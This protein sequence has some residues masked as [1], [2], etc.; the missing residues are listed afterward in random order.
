FVNDLNGNGY[1]DGL[2][3]LNDPLW[4][5]GRDT[6]GNNEVD[7][8][9]GVNFRGDGSRN[10]P[11]DGQGHGTHVSG[12]IG[13]I[14]GNGTG[15]TGVNWQTSLMALRILDD[16]NQGDTGAAIAAV[17]YAT[18][19]RQQLTFA[20]DGRVTAGANVRVLNNS[21]G[22]PGGFEPA[23]ETSIQESAEED[24]LFVAASGNGNFLGQ[25][26]DND[27]T[28]FFPASY[29]SPNVIAVAAGKLDGSLA[30]FSNFGDESVDLVAPGSQ[31]RSTEL[32]GAYGTRNG[33]SMATPH[34]S[35][36]AALI[37]SALPGATVEEVREAIVST[38][39]PITSLTGKVLTGGRLNAANALSA[40]VFAPSATLVSKQDITLAGGTETEF[41]VEYFQRGGIDTNSLGNDDIV[42]NRQWGPAETLA[43]TLKPNSVDVDGDAARATYVVQAPGGSWD[44]LDFGEYR[45]ST[46]AGNVRATDNQVVQQRDVGSFNVRVE[47]PSVLYV[48]TAADV[49]GDG[50]LRDAIALAN[51]AGGARTIILDSGNYNIGIPH[52]ADAMSAFPDPSL[53]CGV[54]ENITGW[55]NET[56]GDFDITGD[57][58]IIG[59]QNDF[60]VIDGQ[61][62][63]RVFKVHPGGRLQLER[64]TVSGGLSP[65][66]QAGGGILSA[67]DL[68]LI[69][70]TVQGNTATGLTN[71]GGIAA[72]GG[73]LDIQRSWIDSNEAARGGGIFL[74]GASDGSITQ[75]T[76]S[77]NSNG[78]LDH[79]AG[80][81]LTVSSSTFSDNEG[82]KGALSAITPSGGDLGDV[83]ADGRFLVFESRID[84]LVP[85]NSGGVFVLDRVLNTIDSVSVANDGAPSDSTDLFAFFGAKPSISDDGRFVAFDSLAG[86]LVPNDTNGSSG[87]V[88]G[89]Q[90]TFVFDRETRTIK[91]V[92]VSN[93]GEQADYGFNFPVEGS[94]PVVSGNGRFV[95]FLSNA[96]NLVPND[97]N[98]QTDVFVYDLQTDTIERAT[99][100]GDGS[101]ANDGGGNFERQQSDLAVHRVSISDD[102]RFVAFDSW[103]DNLVPGD[104]N[105]AHDVFVLDRDTNTVQRVSTTSAGGQAT[106]PAFF[107][108]SFQPEISGDGRFVTFHSDANN[109]VA[110]DTN[111]STDVFGFARTTS[112]IE[113][114]SVA[115]DG[116]E[117][118]A[119]RSDSPD[120][121]DDGRFV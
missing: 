64:V 75:S 99:V 65:E 7:D 92:S 6:D 121:S 53:F 28:P 41:T 66:D 107:R 77:N 103:A 98:F 57:I 47:E 36:T 87:I 81:N 40:S 116:S 112:T 12:T 24:I 110:G 97:T 114:V 63:D 23:L 33:T 46:Q 58:T 86:D 17:N 35:G 109:L 42:V 2:D 11:N 96:D 5:D 108:G 48:D 94:R 50:S 60:T 16:N 54:P 80:S 79:I 25:G 51:A 32:N 105:D 52:A 119:G 1:I 22:Q 93:T 95:A 85:G 73:F 56:T 19:M 91:R 44:I 82:G 100:A 49:S 62:L 20:D 9:F 37:W 38:T 34:V 120:I 67:G 89:G 68:T 61:S 72:W 83:S 26:V 70:S 59:N 21:W 76:I 88:G 101:E 78:G 4:A 104:T 31:V 69:D 55:S 14:G 117:A 10:N 18:K 3:I 113:R 106:G 8:F 30:A 27:R 39:D 118:T 29:D 15:V 45:I 13:A 74:C 71:G 115:N 102:G 84:S 111:D 43:V 90:D